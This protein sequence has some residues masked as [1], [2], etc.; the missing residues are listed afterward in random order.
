MKLE[1]KNH[2]KYVHFLVEMNTYIV[3]LILFIICS[4]LSDKFLSVLNLRNILLQQCAPVLVS[5]GMLMVVLTGGIDLSV[6]SVMAV[7]SS[8]SAVLIT[9]FG[10]SWPLAV[11]VSLLV[12]AV[13]GAFSGFLVA[14]VR[15]Q[16]FVA[17]LAVMTIAR[18]IAYTITNATPIQLADGTLNILTFKAYGYPIIWITLIL[19]LAFV[20]LTQK[21]SYGRLVIATGSNA[22][23]VRLSGIRVK[24]YIM[25]CYVI[26]GVLAT[27]AGVFLA[28]RSGVGNSTVAEGQELDAIAACVIG[29]ASL[30]GGKGSITRTVIGAFILALIGNIMNL[31]SIPPYPQKIIMGLII[32]AAVLMQVLTDKRQ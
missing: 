22:E 11:A 18:G 16:G 21:T 1:T 10:L 15:F 17:T 27:L 7:G 31:M 3:F 13:M 32:V 5:I 19:I 20:F 28:A 30:S 6:G 8:L 2:S 9:N 4:V 24:R 25:S 26:S 29:G 23:A 12:G 14:Y